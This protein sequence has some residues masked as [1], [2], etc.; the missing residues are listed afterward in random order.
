LDWHSLC[1]LV[2]TDKKSSSFF[3]I[4]HVIVIFEESHH[5]FDPGVKEVVL[6]F[7]HGFVKSHCILQWFCFG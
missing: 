3:I 6:L 7:C 5:L 1:E 4:Y 2:L